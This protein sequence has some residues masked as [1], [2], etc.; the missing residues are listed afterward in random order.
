MALEGR[1]DPRRMGRKG[2]TDGSTDVGLGSFGRH[3]EE[4]VD[5]DNKGAGDVGWLCLGGY[6]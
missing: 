6:D 2:R 3:R 1:K 4:M 5:G